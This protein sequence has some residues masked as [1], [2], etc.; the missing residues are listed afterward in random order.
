M[1]LT[2]ERAHW[3]SRLGFVLAAAGSAVGLGNIWRF[4]YVT[5]ENGGGL[6]V[7][8]YLG[9]I[10]LVGLPI[11]MAEFYIGRQTQNSPVGAFRSLSRPG[12]PW[13]GFGW[14]GVIAAFVILSYYSVIAGWCM[15][16][17]WISVTAT[18]QGLD[19]DSAGAMFGE[20]HSN[21]ALSTMWHL[22]FMAITVSIV[23]AGIRQGIEL[24]VK[25]LM[26]LLFLLLF[27]LLIYS[28]TSGAFMQAVDFM[29]RPNMEKVTGA[30]ILAAL[31]QAFFSL[32]LGMGALITYGSYLRRDDD[33]VSTSATVTG[34][35]VMV[36]LMG[37]LV[38]F[39]ILFA[40]GM[41]PQQG[42]GLAFISLPQ[43]FG[44][45][46]GGMLLGPMF[47]L[48]LTFAALTSAISLLE[49]AT[50]YFIDERGWSR[51]KA[52]LGT[53]GL[54]ALLGIP[55]AIAG[56][57]ALFGT[58]VKELT[59]G[60]DWLDLCDHIASNWMLP[61]GG[62][63]IATIVAWKV[64]NDVREAGFKAG[65]KFGALYVGWVLLLRFIV[66]IAV[67]LVFLNAIGAID[68]ITG[69]FTASNNADG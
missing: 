66:P 7:L 1:A 48:L 3:G 52:A 67:L 62:L 38:L 15:H 46:P 40:A 9:A 32:S 61:I 35:D 8:I 69:L 11:M 36:A 59:G 44:T 55:S 25:I 20:L 49:V 53:G 51:T 31:G 43:A 5:G 33:L 29:F 24:W 45:M 64:G 68:W 54:I 12:S 16:Y 10:L 19:G 63:G 27:V 34:L 17:T 47:F 13:M 22:I 23:I 57:S 65:S 60:M 42:V 2:A 26:P 56:G 14:L 4:S 58:E 30:S 18:F 41:D 37:G 39:P 50:A 28:M 6:F 21:P